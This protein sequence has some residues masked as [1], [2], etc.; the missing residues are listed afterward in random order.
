MK[1]GTII[2]TT[3]WKLEANMLLMM[4]WLFDTAN[5]A[6]ATIVPFRE[7]LVTDESATVAAVTEEG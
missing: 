3:P 7:H 5:V 2:T 4:I 1:D 6:P